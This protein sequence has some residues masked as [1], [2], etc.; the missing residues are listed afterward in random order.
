M[1][2]LNYAFLFV[3]DVHVKIKIL[4]NQND[5]IASLRQDYYLKRVHIINIPTPR[6]FT[7][8]YVIKKLSQLILAH[9]T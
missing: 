5:R 4:I 9:S 7:P 6:N 2:P 8:T 1:K 3:R